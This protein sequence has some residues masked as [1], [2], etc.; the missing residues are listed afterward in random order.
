MIF[1]EPSCYITFM[2]VQQITERISDHSSK[3]ER[4]GKLF[5][6]FHSLLHLFRIWM[7]VSRAWNKIMECTINFC[8]QDDTSEMIWFPVVT[9]FCEMFKQRKCV[10]PYLR[11]GPLSEILTIPNLRQITSTIRQGYDSKFTSYDVF[12]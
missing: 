7:Y 8:F 11:L 5:F 1:N 12:Y 4:V 9:R 3:H 2:R 10:K 6:Q